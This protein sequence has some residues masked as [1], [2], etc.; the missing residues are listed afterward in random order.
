MS[1][2]PVR[3]GRE[4]SG[5]AGHLDPLWPAM[6]YLRT[7]ASASPSAWL[8]PW[9]SGRLTRLSALNWMSPPLRSPPPGSLAIPSSVLCPSWQ[10]LALSQVYHTYFCVSVFGARP[11]SGSP[12][13]SGHSAS[14]VS[15]VLGV[16]H[17][18][19]SSMAAC[20]EGASCLPGS[21]CGGG[22]QNHV[23]GRLRASWTTG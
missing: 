8:F 22:R 19:I 5:P 10:S 7:F 16:L 12:I 6:S 4:F 14:T 20:G 17:T 2:K 18:R 23:F 9:V 1:G 15:W 3:L 21:H 13:P 11:H